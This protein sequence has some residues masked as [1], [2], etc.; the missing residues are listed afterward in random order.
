MK[1]KNFVTFVCYLI[2]S[3][4]FYISAVIKMLGKESANWITDMGLGSAFLCLASTHFPKRNND[5]NNK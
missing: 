2:A 4:C 1:N 5:K 3:I